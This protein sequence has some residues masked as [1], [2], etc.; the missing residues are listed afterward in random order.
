MRR[1]TGKITK[2]KWL[3]SGE[4]GLKIEKPNKYLTT[5]A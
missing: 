1:L 2:K 3:L 5:E 4:T